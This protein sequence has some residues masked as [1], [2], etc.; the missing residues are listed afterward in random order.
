MENVQI[1]TTVELLDELPEDMKDGEVLIDKI[2][3]RYS[4]DQSSSTASTKF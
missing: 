4:V 2:G 1:K 3:A